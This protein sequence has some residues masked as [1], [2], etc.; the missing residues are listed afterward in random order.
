MRRCIDDIVGTY[1][2]QPKL[3]EIADRHYLRQKLLTFKRK[4]EYIRG[5]NMGGNLHEFEIRAF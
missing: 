5:R 4:A 1:I 2:I 3:D